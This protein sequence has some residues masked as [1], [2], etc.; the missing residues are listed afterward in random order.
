MWELNYKESWALK[1]WCF[2]TVVLEKTLESPLDC[3][4]IQPVNPKGNHSWISIG[5]NDAEAETSILW[6]PDGKNWLTGKTLML[7][8][9]EGGR[10][11]RW[12]RM[13]W[14]DR[15]TDVMDMSLSKLWQLVMDREAWYVAVHGVAK[16]Q[17]LLSNWTELNWCRKTYYPNDEINLVYLQCLPI[18]SLLTFLLTC[19]CPILLFSSLLAYIYLL[20]I[21]H[22]TEEHNSNSLTHQKSIRIV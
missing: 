12:Q 2:W 11:S 10:R 22:Q 14:L 20:W 16:S 5:G 13:R 17:T 15:I 1:N 4:E 21:V 18:S 8:K 3:K 9:I 6:P 19:R 7:G